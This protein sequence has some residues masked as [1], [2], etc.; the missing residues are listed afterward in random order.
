MDNGAELIGRRVLIVEDEFLLAIEL[1]ALLKEKGCEVLG[2]AL[3][4][5]GALAFVYGE[6]SDFALLDV[7]LKG[8]RATPVAAALRERGVPF[9][10]LTGYSRVQPSEGGTRGRAPFGQAAPGQKA[11]KFDSAGA[12]SHVA[13]LT[14]QRDAFKLPHAGFG[15]LIAIRRVGCV[16]LAK[17][18]CRRI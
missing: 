16:E 9:V 14:R 8:L 5:E 12:G 7:N 10:L 18:R 6:E 17:A 3:T 11:V 4:V 1:E 2:P 13:P 15:S